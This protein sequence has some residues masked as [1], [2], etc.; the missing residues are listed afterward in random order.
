MENTS[1]NALSFAFHFAIREP[2]E[3]D[4]KSNDATHSCKKMKSCSRGAE[5]PGSANTATQRTVA[6]PHDALL[7]ILAY[8]GAHGQKWTAKNHYGRCSQSCLCCR[9]EARAGFGECWECEDL[10]ELK[11]TSQQ[12]RQL[13]GSYDGR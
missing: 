4:A 5:Q 1:H 2:L 8:V 11:A 10:R 3:N 12:M 9:A 7:V 6:I 13:V